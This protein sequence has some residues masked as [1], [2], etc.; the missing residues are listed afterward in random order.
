MKYLNVFLIKFVACLVIFWV[1]LG[2]FFEATLAVIVSFSLV[3]ATIS[4]FIGDLI[5]LPRI[6][7][8]NA[9]IVDFFLTY[10]I[11]WIFGS[12]FFHNYLQIGWGSIIAATLTAGSELFL[13]SYLLKHVKP[14]VSEKQPHFNQSFAFEFAEENEPK[15]KKD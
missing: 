1:S 11:V 4:F 15:P 9:V 5:L 13:H 2:L 12:V 6:G 10:L 14:I 7:N 8:K 3:T